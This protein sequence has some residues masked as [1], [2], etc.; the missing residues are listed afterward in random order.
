MRDAIRNAP[1]T[2]RGSGKSG[3][4]RIDA[5]GQEVLERTAVRLCEEFVEARVELGLPAAG[6]RVMGRQAEV[7]L[8]GALPE[9]A[10]QALL[11]EGILEEQAK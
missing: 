6:R 7:L 10:R 5:G 11:A 4:I 1:D 8:C 3:V 9:I 2:R